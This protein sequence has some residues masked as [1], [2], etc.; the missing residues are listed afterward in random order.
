MWTVT[1]PKSRCKG[2]YKDVVLSSNVFLT[3]QNDIF[4]SF[5]CELGKADDA[6]RHLVVLWSPLRSHSS[7]TSSLTWLYWRCIDGTVASRPADS[8]Q[9]CRHGAAVGH[10]DALPTCRPTRRTDQELGLRTVRLAGVRAL[11]SCT[12]YYW[13]PVSIQT[14]ATHTTQA[15]ARCVRCVRCVNEKRKR[16]P[17]NHDWLLRSTIPIGWRLRLL[18]EKSYAM[19]A[20]RLRQLR[21]LHLRTFVFACVIFLRLLRFLRTFYFA[22]IFFL[23]QDLA[24]VACVWMETGLECTTNLAIS[25]DIRQHCYITSSTRVT[26]LWERSI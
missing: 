2:L 14:H 6:V 16:L 11:K 9:L 20:W 5:V 25:R 12:Y 18:R 10:V 4:A 22:C 1:L 7:A 19:T 24:C 13:S 26:V 17:G 21:D 3:E 23:T 15:L 8:M